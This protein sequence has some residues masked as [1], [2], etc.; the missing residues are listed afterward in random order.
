M[1]YLAWFSNTHCLPSAVHC[2][3]N[4]VKAAD[5]MMFHDKETYYV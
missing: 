4:D 1:L 2:D 5:K 3:N